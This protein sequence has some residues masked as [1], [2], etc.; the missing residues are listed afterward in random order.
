MRKLKQ[1]DI[2]K[3]RERDDFLKGGRNKWLFV[4]LIFID[5]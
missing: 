2:N 4:N 5:V 3:E 1:R